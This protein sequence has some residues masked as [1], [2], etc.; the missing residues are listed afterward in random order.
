MLSLSVS[1]SLS[2][3]L[4]LYLFLYLSVSLS[5][6]ISIYLSV[7]LYVPL[8]VSLY[9]SL[10]LS[11]SLSV[12]LSLSHRSSAYCNLAFA[13]AIRELPWLGLF[14]LHF[15]VNAQSTFR[16]LVKKL[17]GTSWGCWQGSLSSDTSVMKMT[18]LLWF[19]SYLSDFLSIYFVSDLSP[20]IQLLGFGV[21]KRTQDSSVNTFFSQD[22]QINSR[23]ILW[24]SS[25]ICV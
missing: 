14:T 4:C 5:L 3:S 21:L 10:C 2:I 13:A 11:L 6:C 25:L 1:M 20:L 17:Q 15:A 22:N 24:W 19:F 7:C 23:I 9:P 18:M 8:S 16:L 12:C